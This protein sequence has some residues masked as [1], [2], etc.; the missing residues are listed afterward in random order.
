MEWMQKEQERNTYNPN[1]YDKFREAL[2]FQKTDNHEKRIQAAESEIEKL[3]ELFRSGNHMTNDNQ[4]PVMKTNA[5]R[6]DYFNL[7]EEE[8]AEQKLENIVL[9]LNEVDDKKLQVQIVGELVDEIKEMLKDIPKQKNN[10]RRQ[11]LLMFHEALKQNYTKELF[12]EIQVKALVEISRVCNE[13]FVTKEQYLRMDD[14]LCDCN[15]DMMPD[16][17]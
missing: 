2:L 6:D 11:T 17:E 14:V 7:R 12:S 13:K 9:E 3:Y 10:Y 5:R 16:L 8:R 1:L 15:L 4:I